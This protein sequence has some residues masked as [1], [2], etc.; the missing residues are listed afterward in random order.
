M[1]FIVW[2]IDLKSDL[3]ELVMLISTFTVA[4]LDN[5][6]H[7]LC[8]YIFKNFDR[9]SGT[10]TDSE[11]QLVSNN[12]SVPSSI[13]RDGKRQ[14]P[15]IWKITKIIIGLLLHSVLTGMSI[16]M[17]DS[18]DE[19]IAGLLAIIPHKL[20]VLIVLST[21]TLEINRISRFIHIM[22][23]SIAMPIGF[24]LSIGRFQMDFKRIFI[25]YEL[26]IVPLSSSSKF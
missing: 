1:K 23:F 9:R 11:Q 16:G 17:R 21:M 6:I 8:E 15:V 20:T 13:E 26:F 7:Q 18:K 25:L 24:L 12:P 3:A 14:K 22:M 2:T 19:I 4:M 5:L 10:T